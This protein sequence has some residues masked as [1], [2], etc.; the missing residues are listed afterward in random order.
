MSIV[1]GL[2]DLSIKSTQDRQTDRQ[3]DKHTN[4]STKQKNLNHA[5]THCKHLMYL[6]LSHFPN[7]ANQ[8]L[9]E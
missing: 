4:N 1:S 6:N 3:A 8:I 7:C 2:A 9:M 5:N